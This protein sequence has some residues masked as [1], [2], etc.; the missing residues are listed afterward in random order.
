MLNV[1]LVAVV[2][3]LL[4]ADSVYPLPDLLIDTL[5]NVAKPFTAF[6][7]VVPLNVPPPGFVPM[8]MVIAV[9]VV[10]TEF[11]PASCNCTVT[12]GVIE[13][14]A[15]VFVGCWTNASF[16]AGPTVMLNAE[17]VMVV[18]PVAAAVRV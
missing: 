7:D 15:A 6:C 14:V 3:P 18:N 1:V 13:A 2:N 17:L 10:V 16:A 12:A 9:P 4:V 8:A 11:P 5:L